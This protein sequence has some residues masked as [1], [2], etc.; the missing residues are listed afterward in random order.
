MPFITK[1]LLHSSETE[2][3]SSQGVCVSWQVIHAASN[4][5]ADGRVVPSSRSL[6]VILNSCQMLGS[7]DLLN[8]AWDNMVIPTLRKRQMSAV[9]RAVSSS[10]LRASFIFDM[11]SH[12]GKGLEDCLKGEGNVPRAV[13]S[14]W[15]VER[16]RLGKPNCCTVLH[17]ELYGWELLVASV[18]NEY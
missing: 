10:Y 17:I 7:Q 12:I 11:E 9:P 6:V 16:Q 2:Q 1:F 3:N 8:E 4:Y 13:E 5:F 15:T 18:V 14:I